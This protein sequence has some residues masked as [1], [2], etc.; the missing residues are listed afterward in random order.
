M[1]EVHEIV[2]YC[3]ERL[4]AAEYRDVAV[5]GLQVSGA[6]SVE[7]L[8]LAVSTSVHTLT[9]ADDWGADAVL[10]HHGLLWGNAV[11]PIVGTLAERL[12]ILFQNDMNLLAYHLPLD[13]HSEIGN[14]ALLAK[15]LGFKPTGQFAEIAGNPIGTLAQ[16]DTALRADELSNKL[17]FVL[18]HTP[19]VVGQVDEPIQKVGVVTGSGYSTVGEASALGCQALITGDIREPTMAEARELGIVVFAAGHE[20]TERF[21]VQALGEELA[22]EFGLET[23]YFHDPNPL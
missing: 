15:K 14:C 9:A 20:A 8:G 22:G 12:R 2:D 21:G 3:N 7:R 13:G 19:I 5:N 23:R 4:L 18:D 11:E 1:V 16:S 17:Q 10:V 6:T